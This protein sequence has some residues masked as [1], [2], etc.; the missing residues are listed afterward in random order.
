MVGLHGTSLLHEYEL[1][2]EEFSLTD[3]Q[4]AQFATNS[5]EAS[6]PTPLCRA[7]TGSA[8]VGSWNYELGIDART[9]RRIEHAFS[10]L[11]RTI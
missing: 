7:G 9:H 6:G 11:A 5:I 10:E 3:R 1:C 2:R 4:L 8:I